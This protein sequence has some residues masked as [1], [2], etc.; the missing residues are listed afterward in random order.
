MGDDG[1]CDSKCSVKSFGRSI[2]SGCLNG[3]FLYIFYQEPFYSG[4]PLP[5]LRIIDKQHGDLHFYL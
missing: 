4:N 2:V 3:L 1:L 5:Y